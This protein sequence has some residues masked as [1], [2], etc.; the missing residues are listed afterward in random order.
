M[1]VFG[2]AVGVIGFLLIGGACEAG[3]IEY[4][5]FYS[6]TVPS[7]QGWF[8]Y[9]YSGGDAIL[10]YGLEVTDPDNTKEGTFFGKD[11]LTHGVDITR[12][13]PFEVRALFRIT[14]YGMPLGDPLR[15]LFLLRVTNGTAT[16]G[17]SMK[18]GASRTNGVTTIGFVST[19][20]TFF[21]DTC[22]SSSIDFNV[23]L[24][25]EPSVTGVAM[26]L[27]VYVMTTPVTAL[28][29]STEFL[30]IGNANLRHVHV[31]MIG[32]EATGTVHVVGFTAGW[33]TDAAPAIMVPPSGT[34][35]FLN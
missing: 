21:G 17:R 24:W 18:L 30:Y 19:N 33:D 25:R 32:K 6:R 13:T 23:V 5:F 34:V 3:T 11:K 16:Y 9:I 27:N 22:T 10:D 29:T 28:A 8:K 14:D 20:G 15:P 4:Q 35:V 2:F 31:G 26:A 7:D 12:T 1:V